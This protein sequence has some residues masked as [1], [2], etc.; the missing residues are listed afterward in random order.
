MEKHLFLRAEKNPAGVSWRAGLS[1]GIRTLHPAYFAL[2]MSTGIIS[3]AGH[4]LGINLIAIPLFW[5]NVAAYA[6]LWI[7]YIGRV[8]WY[9]GD[10]KNDFTDHRRAPGYFTVVAASGVLGNQVLIIGKNLAV[11]SGLGVVTFLLW[12]GLIYSV[13]TA[14]ITK[15]PKPAITEGL[16]GAWLLP[17]VATQAV[18]VLAAALA[19]HFSSHQEG[20]L[21]LAFATWL[22]GGM[23]YIWIIALIFYRY[24]FFHLSPQDLT[25]PYWINMGAV[26]IS[27]LGGAGL[28][29][30]AQPGSFL[31]ELMPFLKGLTFFFWSTAT[32]WIPMLG[33]LA[34]WRHVCRKVPLN[35][36]P[37]FWGAVFPLGMYTACTYKLG[38]V[39]G[40]SAIASIPGVF[41]YIAFGAW[42]AVF[43]GMLHRLF[44]RLSAPSSA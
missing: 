26:A 22:F 9:P 21:L 43:L 4:F 44:A 32:W 7:L 41:I 2:V 3:L 34:G 18:T 24:L 36:D 16:N 6:V 15:E 8:V 12:I 28:I 13:F 38:Q 1:D 40:L 35:Y 27:T 25:P 14:L 29:A 33:L 5:L 37:L 39:T 11:A 19:P 23:L 17:I 30:N 20:M 42:L 31:H 10:V